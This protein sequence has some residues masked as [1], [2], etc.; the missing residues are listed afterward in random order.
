MTTW[1]PILMMTKMHSWMMMTWMKGL[2]TNAVKARTMVAFRSLGST[3]SRQQV[4]AR[5]HRSEWPSGSQFIDN[6][7]ITDSISLSEVS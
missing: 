2:Y 3:V 4:Q 5:Y 1:F 7:T 6:P